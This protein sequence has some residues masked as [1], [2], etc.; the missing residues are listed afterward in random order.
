MKES[1]DENIKEKN[2]GITRKR[3]RELKIERQKRKRKTN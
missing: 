2:R 1:K 3:K